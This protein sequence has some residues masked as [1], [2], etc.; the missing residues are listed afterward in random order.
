MPFDRFDDQGFYQQNLFSDS[1]LGFAF[2]LS[3]FFPLPSL[4]NIQKVDAQRK[5][6]TEEI[7][8]IENSWPEALQ[9]AKAEGKYI[10]VDGYAT[11]CGPCKKLKATT[12]KDNK[13]A[14][15]FN[16]HFVNVAID[17]EKGQGPK[18]AEKWGLEVYPALFIFDSQ[19][20]LIISG[21]GFLD[22]TEMI[23]FRQQAIKNKN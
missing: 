23:E 11:W 22:A 5:D 17:M 19:G 9:R 12:F 8:F 20:R 13:A 3:S 6:K 15:F 1:F 14:A 2:L 7:Q 10:F 21:E 4:Q 16:K 18:L